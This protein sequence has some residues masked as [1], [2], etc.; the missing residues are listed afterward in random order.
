MLVVNGFDRVSGPE[1]VRCDSLA[2]FRMDL[3]GGPNRVDISFIGPSGSS[4]SRRRVATSTASPLGALRP[5]LRDRRDRRQYVRLSGPAAVRSSQRAIRSVR[6][7]ARAVEAYPTVE[8]SSV[9]LGRRAM[10]GGRPRFWANLAGARLLHPR[11]TWRTSRSEARSPG[12]CSCIDSD[13]D[14]WP[15]GGAL[16]VSRATAFR[17]PP[18][19]YVV[20]GLMRSR[21]D[22]CFVARGSPCR[23]TDLVRRR[24]A[25]PV[26]RD[27]LRFLFSDK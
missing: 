6:H 24:A 7:R 27:V 10:A 1:S 2:G 9:A 21:V 3:D 18:R 12:R 8:A 22:G 5:Q 17:V 15:T 25:R 26:M 16:F 14:I 19:P 4:T 20:G 23:R 13:G 11:T